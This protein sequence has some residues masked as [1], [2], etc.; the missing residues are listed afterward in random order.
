VQPFQFVTASKS[1]STSSD[2]FLDS[3][4]GDTNDS[5]LFRYFNYAKAPLP[6]AET[7]DVLAASAVLGKIAKRGG[8]FFGDA[9]VETQV[10]DA[11]QALQRSEQGRYGAILLLKELA[12][13][14]PTYFG[15]H[16]G[17]I[18]DKLLIG[19]RD[20]HVSLSMLLSKRI[21]DVI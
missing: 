21:N 17:L 4:P 3:S 7:N 1:D 19:F 12:R 5:R 6:S 11:I 10:R 16:I 18:F 14:L 2:A 13:N 9:F 15:V 8:A 20:A